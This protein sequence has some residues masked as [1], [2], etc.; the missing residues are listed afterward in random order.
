MPRV[1]VEVTIS[2]L[3]FHLVAKCLNKIKVL[4]SFNLLWSDRVFVEDFSWSVLS[5]GPAMLLEP[6]RHGTQQEDTHEEASEG[7]LGQSSNEST[8]NSCNCCGGYHVINVERSVI[9]F[10][11]VMSEE[12]SDDLVAQENG[13]AHDNVGLSCMPYESKHSTRP[14]SVSCSLEQ[15]FRWESLE[16]LSNEI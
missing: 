9:V 13:S 4:D 6:P 16:R 15:L 3:P 12:V 10:L 11:F 5:V 1:L 2:I 14:R 7:V 8:T